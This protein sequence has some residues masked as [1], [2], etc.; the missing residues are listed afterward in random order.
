MKKTKQIENAQTETQYGAFELKQ[1]YK[2]Y[3]TRGLIFAAA[4]HVFVATGIMLS[5]YFERLNAEKTEDVDKRPPIIITEI[6]IPPVVKEEEMKTPDVPQEKI[7]PKKDLAALIPQPVK[8]VE[9]TEEVKFKAQDELNKVDDNISS[10]GDENANN[11]YTG[12][13]DI[14]DKK[15]D[16]N[17]EK[18]PPVLKD[19]PKEIFQPFEVSKAPNAVNLSQVQGSMNYPTFA[20]DNG[21]EGR[22]TVKVLVGTDGSVI[23]VG[24]IS[25]PSEFHDEVRSNVRDL[26][27]TPAVNNGEL[28]KCWVS[29]PFNFKLKN[30]F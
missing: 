4:L 25:G 17:I 28:V 6:D 11:N 13:I 26:Q 5:I 15:I 9:V 22:V 3:M 23:K 30:G 16:D 1:V 21:I 27:F 7:I 8:K 24:S 18:D 14:N 2:K 19:P 29:V 10:K 12:K 20:R